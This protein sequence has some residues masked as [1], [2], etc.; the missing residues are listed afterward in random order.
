MPIKR[1]PVIMLPSD[2]AALTVDELAK[3]VEIARAAGVP[4][5]FKVKAITTIRGTW[6]KTVSVT[7]P[8]APSEGK[9]LGA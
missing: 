3:F 9:V 1:Q 5:S 7:P 6:L 2:G 8:E 4:G